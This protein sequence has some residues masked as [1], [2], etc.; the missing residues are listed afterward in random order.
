[1]R[2]G[3]MLEYQSVDYPCPRCR[4]NQRDCECTGEEMEAW[5]EVQE[6]EM[7]EVW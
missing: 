6:E 4:E 3:K 1:M 2:G 5:N 7:Q